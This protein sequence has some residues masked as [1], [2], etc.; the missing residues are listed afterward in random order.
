MD[1]TDCDDC[2]MYNMD[3]GGNS[4]L[5]GFVEKIFFKIRGTIEK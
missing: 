4:I 3:T 5:R 2:F 1:F